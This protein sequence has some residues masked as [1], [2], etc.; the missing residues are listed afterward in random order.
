MH[1]LQNQMLIHRDPHRALLRRRPPR[2]KHHAITAHLDHRV[3]HLLRQQLPSL[4]LVRV[5]L[6]PAH[7]QACV[8]EQDA[9]VRPWC[10]EPAVLGRRSEGRVV[11]FEALVD[12]L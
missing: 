10:E 3:N 1:T 2:H 8:E 7:R 12:I 4:A 6:A 5:G 9:A 11:P